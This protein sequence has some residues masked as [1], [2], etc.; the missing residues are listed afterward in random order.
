MLLIDNNLS[1]KLAKRLQILFPG[2]VHVL[3][4]GLGQEDD[5]AVWNYATAY[6]LHILTKDSDFVHMVHLKGFPPKVIRLNTGNVT[7][8]YIEALLIKEQATIMQFLQS[9][10]H[11]LLLLY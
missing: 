2:T 10:D 1:P 3:D 7:T 6:S 5:H 9:P 4:L 8:L 11:G